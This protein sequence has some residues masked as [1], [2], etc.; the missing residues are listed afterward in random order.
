MSAGRLSSRECC[1]NSSPPTWSSRPAHRDMGFWRKCRITFR[2]FRF[3]VWA[4]VIVL[5]GAFLWFNRVGLP[6]F[7]KTR[8]VAAMREQGVELEFSRLRLSLVRGL[9]ADNVRA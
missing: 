1:T 6:D 4:L 2:W 8:L 7:M 3:T 5:I 9:V